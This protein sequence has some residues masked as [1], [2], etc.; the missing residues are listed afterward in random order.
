MVTG[1]A[2]ELGDTWITELANV[3][4]EARDV[5]LTGLTASAAYQFRV[6][7]VNSVGE[8]GTSRPSNIVLLPQEGRR[9]AGPDAA[10]E[11]R[12]I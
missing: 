8:G 11:W 9:P 1:A 10:R 4:A 7:A 6:S 2:P 3:S 5:T 12:V